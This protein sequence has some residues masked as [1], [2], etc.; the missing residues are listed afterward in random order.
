MT[1]IFHKIT[2]LNNEL[3]ICI[4]TLTFNVDDSTESL[5]RNEKS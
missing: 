5:F 2:I 4:L 1:C 3:N